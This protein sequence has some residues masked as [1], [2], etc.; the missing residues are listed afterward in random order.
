MLKVSDLEKAIEQGGATW[1]LVEF[2]DANV[3]SGYMV[4]VKGFKRY[5]VK[6]N[7]FPEVILKKINE[8]LE[9]NKYYVMHKSAYLGAWINENACY[10]DI[11]LNI[12]D[13]EDAIKIGRLNNQAAIWDCKNKK[14]IYL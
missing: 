13:E 9:D 12:E 11:S 1:D 3:E 2:K 6:E 8:L 14:E 4:G 5:K 10:I 7:W